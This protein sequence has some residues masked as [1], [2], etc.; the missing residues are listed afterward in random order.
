M[1]LGPKP[2]EWNEF[3]LFSLVVLNEKVLYF[4]KQPF[5]QLSQG[6]N[7]LMAARPPTLQQ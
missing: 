7:V 2:S 3:F 4:P 6:L 5:G 1:S